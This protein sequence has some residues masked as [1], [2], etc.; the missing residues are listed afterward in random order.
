VGSW[1]ARRFNLGEDQ[2]RALVAAGAGAGIGAAFNAPIAG[3]LFALEVILRSF[4]ARHM[5]GIVLASVSAAITSQ[6]L[7]GPEL[8]LSAGVY[9]LGSF[10]ELLPY[11]G[12]ALVVVIVGIFFLQLL[13]RM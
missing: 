10:A 13:D 3:M 11:A 12:L 4:S 1:V 6:S 8:A 9:H 5:S 2:V 7:V